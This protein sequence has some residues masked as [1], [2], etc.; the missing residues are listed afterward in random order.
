MQKAE[1]EIKTLILVAFLYS[2]PKTM[3]IAAILTVINRVKK[4]IPKEF[5]DTSA[6]VNGLIHS[7]DKMVAIGYNKPQAA[8]LN[9]RTQL[10]RT[11]PSG[12]KIT[13]N[14]PKE[15]NDF[16]LKKKD[17]WAEAKGSPNVTNYPK[18]LK[19]MINDLGG[20]PMATYETGKKPITVWQKA[21]LD[22]R[23]NTK[24]KCSKTYEPKDKTYVG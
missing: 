12:T 21:E 16:L 15:L 11:A 2:Q 20:E 18:E 14:N 23:Y 6:Y 7:A 5:G 8:Y 1:T 17:L 24:C 19:K 9:A 4:E 22:T 10:L 13:I 3:L